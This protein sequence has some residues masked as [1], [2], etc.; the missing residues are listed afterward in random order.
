M[1]SRQGQHVDGGKALKWRHNECNGVSNHRRL[2]F[3]PNR[4]FRLRSKQTSS[5]RVTGLC[6]GN[7]RSSVNSPHIGPVT[8]KMFP[9]GDVIKCQLAVW[10]YDLFCLFFFLLISTISY[11]FISIVIIL[12]YLQN[13]FSLFRLYLSCSQESVASLKSMLSR[14]LHEDHLEMMLLA[15]TD[16]FHLL[17]AFCCNYYA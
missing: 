8:R 3:L 16:K 10:L 13:N 1:S 11:I 4:L 6:E 15:H 14:S 9:F 5:P 7:H 12:K 2:D 17:L